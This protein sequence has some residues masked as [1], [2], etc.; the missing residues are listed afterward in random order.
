MGNSG[1]LLVGTVGQGIMRSADG[2]ESWNRAGPSQGFHSDGVVR[3]LVANPKQLEVLFA[4]T[5][6]GLYR[7]DDA[8]AHWQHLDTPMNGQ[9]VWAVAVDPADP[10]R[11]LAGTGT[12]TPPSIYQSTDGGTTWEQRR[13]Q[14]AESCPAVG[15]PRPTAIAIDPADPRSVWLGVEVDGTRRSLD[16]GSTWDGPAA[17]I[18]NRDVHNVLVT[19][20]P[21][22]RVFVLVNDDVWISADDGA[23]WANVG[24]RQVFPWHYPRGITVRPDD[25]RTVFVTVG[26]TTPG[27]TGAIMRTRDAGDTWESLPLPGQPNSAMWAVTCSR[28]NPDQMFAGSRY[29]YLYRSD[30]GGDSWTRYW[31]ELS[32]ISAIA[33]VPA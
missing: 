2:G 20:G 9:A 31:R 15:V 11:V 13:A 22:K 29:G 10:S 32:E 6:Q 1:T 12:P 7:T 8:G 14:F 3:C 24:V 27:R 33:Y 17:G 16:G 5:D 28:A 30:D 23:S 4:G 25:P 26:D 18:M 19:G 21:D